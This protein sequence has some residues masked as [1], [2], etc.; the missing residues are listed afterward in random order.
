[1]KPIT[2]T[3]ADA[4]TILAN[5]QRE[6][7]AGIEHR[8]ARVK[9]WQKNDDRVNGNVK[10]PKRS[11][12]NFH[13]PIL[14]GFE[15][16]LVSKVD[17][18]PQLKFGSDQ[19]GEKR[20]GRK[21]DELYRQ[22]STRPGKEWKMAD[23]SSKR[24]SARYGRALLKMVG[25]SKPFNIEL[26]S[27]DPYD[28]YCDPLC[29]DKLSRARYL[30]VEPIFKSAFQLEEGVK[31]GAYDKEAVAAL[32]DGPDDNAQ[33][34]TLSEAMTESM[35]RFASLKLD[36]YGYLGIGEKQYRL[37][38]SGTTY[39]GVRYYCVWSPEGQQLL[40]CQPLS[41][42]FGIPDGH[43]LWHIVSWAPFPDKKVFWS[44]APDDD[45]SDV[46]EF[47]RQTMMYAA[48]GLL[49][50][51]WGTRVYDPGVFDATDLFFQ[52]GGLAPSKK[53]ASATG[54]GLSGAVHELKTPEYS[55]AFNLIT[56]L[57]SFVGQKTGVTP[58]AQGASDQDVLGIA[59]QNI[60]QISDRMGLT[61]KHYQSA[62]IELG[63]LFLFMAK[64]LLKG[65][66]AVRVI[67]PEGYEFEEL[68]AKDIDPSIAITVRGGRAEENLS[69]NKRSEKVKALN[70]LAVNPEM[71]K[72]MV[73]ERLRLAGYEDAE[74]KTLTDEAAYGSSDQINRA[75]EA[76]EQLLEGKE[77]PKLYQGAD[78]SYVKTI[79]DAARRFT[80][81]DGPEYDR[82]VAYAK[83][84]VDIVGQNMAEELLR[85]T[86]AGPTQ[87]PPE[88]E[89]APEMAPELAPQGLPPAPLP[90]QAPPLPAPIPL[91]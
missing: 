23:L 65:K 24:D 1:M 37:V 6:Y 20:I 48:D 73:D 40:R 8:R 21:Y 11:L 38:E 12:N 28:F 5:L 13:L 83:A 16:T 31:S 14:A 18:Q 34:A 42:V 64:H 57:D 80:D 77:P 52:P 75:G 61:S 29:G 25:F 69:Q 89:V 88:G 50:N 15:D 58:D 33:G 47:Q 86:M 79:L 44:K 90:G 91:Q 68:A 56:S 54:A 4:A 19:P 27:T 36:G 17:D 72:W 32:C 74:V 30:G 59:E 51:V 85:E 39:K 55:E 60:E 41:K 45:I 84:H 26:H 9:N 63:Q 71:P 3:T 22:C 49:K 66:E 46:A 43:E 67:G 7:T 2:V 82:L 78:A 76:V 10:A 81:S 35:S 87:P 62:Y 70:D 53:G